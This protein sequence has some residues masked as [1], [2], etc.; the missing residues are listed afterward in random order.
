MKKSKLK[1]IISK[2]KHANGEPF[3]WIEI[4]DHRVIHKDKP[5]KDLEPL[6]DK[7]IELYKDNNL[8]VL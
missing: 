8:Q 3:F 4:N 1:V 7:L 5:L 2:I 6:R